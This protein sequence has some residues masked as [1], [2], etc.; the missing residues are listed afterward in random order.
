[1]S[2]DVFIELICATTTVVQVVSGGRV[3]QVIGVVQVVKVSW[4]TLPI[5]ARSHG[6]CKGAGAPPFLLKEWC[7]DE[8]APPLVP[9]KRNSF[10]KFLK[11]SYKLYSPRKN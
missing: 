1:M 7:N 10:H 5:Q 8:F 6:G 3:V 9:Y 11:S 2:I 4:D